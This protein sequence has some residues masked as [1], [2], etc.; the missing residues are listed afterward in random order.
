MLAATI[1]PTH[2]HSDI[3]DGENVCAPTETNAEADAPEVHNEDNDVR[4]KNFFSARVN[5]NNVLKVDAGPAW[6]TSKMYYNSRNG[7]TNIASTNITIDYNHYWKNG[8]GFGVNLMQSHF[9]L[10]DFG[11]MNIFYAGASIS[12]CRVTTKTG[13][14][15]PTWDWAIQL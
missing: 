13:G 5:K 2:A 15:L 4:K 8:L 11:S 3:I 9:R 10:E 6:I 1:Q 14:G 7:H 12:V